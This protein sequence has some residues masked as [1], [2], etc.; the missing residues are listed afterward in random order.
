MKI[1]VSGATGFVGSHFLNTLFRNGHTV[2]ALRRKSNKPR[3]ELINK[4]I[5]CTGKLTDDWSNKLKDC[6][7]FVHLASAGVNENMNNWDYCFDVNVNQSLALWKSAI[8]NGINKFLICG[9]CSEYGKSG[10][11]YEYLPTNAE[12]K[13]IGAYGTSKAV[14]SLSALGLARTF[15]LKLVVARLFHT[16]GEGEA[17]TRF[18]PSL[19]KASMDNV[20]FDMSKGEQIRDFTPVEDVSEKL[21]DLVISLADLK[22][23]GTIKNIGTG[24]PISLLDFA[25]EQ[26]V[27]RESKGKL[28]P[29]AL[30]YR[31]Q[32]VMRYVPLIK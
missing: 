11:E 25:N 3:I 28:I 10:E 23:G 18:W 17:E 14:A 8:D 32:E 7:A 6:D 9:S 13:P 31:K 4:P 21:F 22:S 29:G 20:D 2:V 19:L 30:P 27:K 12:L 16:Y 1:F 15:D 26:W 24:I 5:W